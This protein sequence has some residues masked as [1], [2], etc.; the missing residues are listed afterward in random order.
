[1][2]PTAVRQSAVCLAA[3]LLLVAPAALTCRGDDAPDFSRW[4]KDIAAFQRQDADALPPR[5]AVLF[6]GSSSIRLWDLKKSFPDLDVI[7]RGFGGS[8]IADS[9]HF[10]PRIIL[11]ARPRLIV[12][13]AGDN[14]IAA[15]RTPEQASADFQDFAALA[16]KELP[17][18]RIVFL[19][20]KPSPARWGM[21]DKQRAAN[22]LIEAYCKGND[23]LTYLD[24]GTP[25]LGDDGKPREELFVKDGLHLN[26][27]GYALWASL[28]KPCLK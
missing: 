14:D 17:K 21:V 13:Y 15:G 22:K 8:Q 24:V 5:D 12:F 3:V 4:E 16:H 9:T 27:K 20:I 18:T 23:Y 28:L 1:M 26:E 19:S 2:R 11:K 10:A 7:N 25:M 6:A